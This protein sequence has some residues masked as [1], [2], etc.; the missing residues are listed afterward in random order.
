MMEGRLQLQENEITLLKS[1]LA[2]A[3]RRLRLH[4]QLIPLLRQQLIAGGWPTI[5]P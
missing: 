4:D 3:L 5:T 1:S 2:D